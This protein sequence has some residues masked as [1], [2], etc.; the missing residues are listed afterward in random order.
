[1]FNESCACV[2]TMLFAVVGALFCLLARMAGGLSVL[3]FLVVISSNEFISI[4][5]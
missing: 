3:A 5:S 1:M 4:I 2:D